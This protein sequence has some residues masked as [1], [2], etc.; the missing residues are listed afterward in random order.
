LDNPGIIE[1]TLVMSDT[2][3][4]TREI[5]SVALSQFAISLVFPRI[6]LLLMVLQ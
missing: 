6:E 3:V 1:H 2:E 4:H 5:D